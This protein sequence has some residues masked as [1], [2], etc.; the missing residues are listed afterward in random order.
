[1]ADGEEELTPTDCRR[2]KEQAMRL[3][4]GLRISTHTVSVIAS[5]GKHQ[6]SQPVAT[7][8]IDP[9]EINVGVLALSPRQRDFIYPLDT[10]TVPLANNQPAIKKA[11]NIT[12]R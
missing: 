2:T 1:M 8:I 9:F 5:A 4:K 6:C 7:S 3:H 11:P 10:C 12:R